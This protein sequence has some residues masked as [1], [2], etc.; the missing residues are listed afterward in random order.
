MQISSTEVIEQGMVV[1]PDD[2]KNFL[3]QKFKGKSSI[4]VSIGQI[5]YLTDDS[6][7]NKVAITSDTYE[8][9]AQETVY[10]VSKEELNVPPGYVAYVFLKN[11]FSQKGFLAF[12]TGIIDGGFRGPISTLATNFSS[13]T[14]ELGIEALNT[15]K[16]FRVVFHKIDLPPEELSQVTCSH[17]NRN[18]YMNYLKSDLR[19]LPKYF[20]DREKLR[21][22]IDASLNNKALNVSVKNIAIILGLL[23][24]VISLAPMVGELIFQKAFQ[25]N[26]IEMLE[27]RISELESRNTQNKPAAKT[28]VKYQVNL[29]NHNETV[30][31]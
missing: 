5:I 13:K 30:S 31:N 19:S 6:D 22:Q 9:E 4:D 14:I 24:A 26:R 3:I 25:G 20:L 11:R 18:D 21:R 23:S 2:D 1:F 10:L 7:K 15:D 28:D 12:N 27:Y 17:Y 29:D 16:F 8:L